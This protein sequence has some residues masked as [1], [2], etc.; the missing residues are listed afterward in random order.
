MDDMYLVIMSC[1]VCGGCPSLVV[2]T[3]HERNVLCVHVC[4]YNN[5][6]NNNNNKIIII[7]I[8]II[9]NNII[10]IIIIAAAVLA[11]DYQSYVSFSKFK[12]MLGC[13]EGKVF[14]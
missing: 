4:M 5:N 2:T 7:I 14:S 10:V 6:N 12:H 8:I 1:A 13:C 11:T 3:R 9:I